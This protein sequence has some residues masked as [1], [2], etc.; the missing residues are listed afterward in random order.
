MTTLGLLYLQVN[1][2]YFTVYM[3]KLDTVIII[4][5]IIIIIIVVSLKLHCTV[6]CFAR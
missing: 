5:I 2:W 1:K 4:I 3:E 6:S